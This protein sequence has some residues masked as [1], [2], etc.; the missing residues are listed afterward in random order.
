MPNSTT[1]SFRIGRESQ[2]ERDRPSYDDTHHDVAENTKASDRAENPL[3]EEQYGQLNEAEGDLF[4]TLESI[5][6]LFH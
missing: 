4:R 1:I 5:F 6:V 3:Q 2:K